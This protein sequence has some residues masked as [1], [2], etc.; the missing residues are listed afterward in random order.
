MYQKTFLIS[1]RILMENE[2]N[3]AKRNDK[4]DHKT[5]R[6][7]RLNRLIE[8]DISNYFLKSNMLWKS[9]NHLTNFCDIVPMN[10][11]LI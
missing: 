5:E 1:G 4:T 8:S 3:K 11:L 6:K 2:Q 10:I 7:T 9:L